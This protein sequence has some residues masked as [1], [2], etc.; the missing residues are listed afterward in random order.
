MPPA[1]KNSILRC[2]TL[3]DASVRPWS[4]SRGE[5]HDGTRSGWEHLRTVTRPA[6]ILAPPTYLDEIRANLV[7]DGVPDAVAR[8]DTPWIFDWLIGVSQ[9]Q[10]ISNANAAAYTA[11]HGIVGW[12][13]I[14]TALD[15]GPACRRL[16]SYWHFE[17][18]GYRKAKGTC[19][20]PE[21]LSSCS[22]PRHPAR[23]GSLIQAAYALHLFVRDICND[24]LVGW[25][26]RRL[27]AADP[28]PRAP[29]RGKRMG[30]AL[31]DPLG[32]IY[33]VGS[34]IWSMALA[35]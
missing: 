26:D 29:D 30:A 8:R 31:L 32:Q 27:A 7:A 3:L 20:E 33:G 9:F 34:K 4:R 18:C 23:K 35:A 22:L 2:L 25:I 13:D 21:H 12:N 24:D 6:L 28:G 17:G 10:G 5:R 1:L 14:R 16:R 19:S 11:K 15:A